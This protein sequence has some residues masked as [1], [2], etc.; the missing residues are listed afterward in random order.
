MSHSPPGFRRHLVLLTVLIT[1]LVNAGGLVS[2]DAKRRL[3]QSRSW[4]TAAPEV[5]SL[6][7]R[8][9]YPGK[10]GVMRTTYGMGQGLILLP[11]DMAAAGLVAI[12]RGLPQ[13]VADGAR[14]A[15]VAFFSQAL[16]GTCALVF[17]YLLLRRLE[18]PHRPAALGTLSLLLAT[19]FLHYQQ[20]CQENN[21][22]LAW[23]LIGTY[24]LATWRE[25]GLARH[26]AAAG[27]AFGCSMLVRPT[28]LAD[29]GGALIFLMLLRPRGLHRF[30]AAFLPP[31]L[32]LVVIERSYQHARFGNWFGTYY[33]AVS[34]SGGAPAGLVYST[35]FFTGVGKAL[36]SHDHSIFLYD[37][38]LVLTL[39]LLVV[40]WR[41]IAPPVRA[42][43]VGA[44]ATLVVY[45]CFYARLSTPAGETS[46]GDRYTETPVLILCLLAVPLLSPL[47]GAAK[48]A[49]VAIIAWSVVVQL[50]SL[51]IFLGVEHSQPYWTIPQRFLNI[52]LVAT[53]QADRSPY[54]AQLP[55]EW[56]RFSLLPFQLFLRFPIL[57][58]WAVAVWA[59]LLA[60][61]AW[62]LR[63]TIRPS[64]R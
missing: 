16:I 28:A 22:L 9:G 14:E 29:L 32:L 64:H 11:A 42:F 53:A 38:L 45:I 23:A 12:A 8:G 6:F 62:Q 46:W 17:A 43:A 24:Y 31:W 55:I 52:W 51:P 7:L 39:I 47:H 59:A 56:R 4:W 36:W 58:R 30:A 35:P 19:T 48:A 25:S 26:A 21:L 44:L 27:V 49:A 40:Y 18:F 61:A 60:A 2:L 5:D 63:L 20:N 33:G 50:A 15:L 13:H 37:P 54:F 34:L 1:A 3:Q 57:A 10:D 41:R